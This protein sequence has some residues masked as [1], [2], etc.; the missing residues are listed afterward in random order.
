MIIG[1]DRPLYILPFDHRAPFQTKMFGWQ[2][3]PTAA[4]TERPPTHPAD[5]LGELLPDAWLETHPQAR[6]K[7]AS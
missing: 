6:R 2:G 4:Q 3:A 1:Y 5:R 7:V